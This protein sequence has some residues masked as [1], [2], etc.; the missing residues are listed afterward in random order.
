MNFNCLLA[1]TGHLGQVLFD[2]SVKSLTLKNVRSCFI[3]FN[4]MFIL[5]FS[6]KQTYINYP[7]YLSSNLSEISYTEIPPAIRNYYLN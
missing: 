5:G 1:T 4:A 2:S 7:A 6:T 3:Y